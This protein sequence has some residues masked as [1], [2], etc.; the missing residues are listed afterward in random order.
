MSIV[1]RHMSI[2]S[3]GDKEENGVK[4]KGLSVKLMKL[5]A[6]FLY[7]ENRQEG[8]YVG[9]STMSIVLR[10]MSIESLGDKEVMGTFVVH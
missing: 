8:H 4:I 2:E 5:W 3:L 9:K 6:L 10:H 7:I 1:L